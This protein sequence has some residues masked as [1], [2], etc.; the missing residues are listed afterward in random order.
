M[1]G[2]PKYSEDKE[3]KAKSIRKRRKGPNADLV[4]V[5]VKA[6]EA[7]MSYGQ[8]VLQE[9]MKSQ[10]SI[11]EERKMKRI[12]NRTVSGRRKRTTP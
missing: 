12:S 11:E 8:Y 1:T 2:K 4:E 9:Q 5:A 6:K 10:V 7:G 3:P